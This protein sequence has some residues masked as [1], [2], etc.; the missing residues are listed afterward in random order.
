[1]DT[2]Q[3][4]SPVGRRLS[5]GARDLGPADFWALTQA[6]RPY[7]KAVVQGVLGKQLQE[8]VDASDVVQQCLL[9]AFEHFEQFRGQG[10]AEWYAWLV[11][12]ARREAL[13]LLRYWSQPGR[14]KDREQPRPAGS[15][16]APQLP[17]D[18]SSPSQK[19]VRREQAARLLAAIERAPADYRDVLQLR[20]FEHLAYADVA[21]R[22]GRSE[23][24]VRQLWVR[25]VK[26]LRQE[27]GEEP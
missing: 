9:A 5:A 22:M 24:A 2:P 3:R 19:A 11:A 8:K 7:L 26:H 6:Y 23:Q 15:S 14:D 25:A 21:T 10:A 18:A 12:I 1:M 13:D 17:A 16:G 20:N 27:L 4:T